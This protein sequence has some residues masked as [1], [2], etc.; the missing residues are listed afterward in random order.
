MFKY[1]KST[2]IKN[3]SREFNEVI[4]ELKEFKL[5]KIDNEF[6]ISIN[7][8]NEYSYDFEKM[9]VIRKMIKRIIENLEIETFSKLNLFIFSYDIVKIMMKQLGN[10]YEIYESKDLKEYGAIL[11]KGKK[12]KKST[13]SNSKTV[14]IISGPNA[15]QFQLRTFIVRFDYLRMIRLNFY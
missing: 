5:N 7:D 2:I 9:H 12:S 4:E 14:V 6:N 10:E 15:V 8:E 3:I 1:C 11:I 13:T